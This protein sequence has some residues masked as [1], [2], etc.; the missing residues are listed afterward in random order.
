M[1]A[2]ADITFTR[3]GKTL[4]INFPYQK[5][6]ESFGFIGAL[7][8]TLKERFETQLEDSTLTF[9]SINLFFNGGFEIEELKSSILELVDAIDC[10][11]T[12]PTT[13]WKLP[14]CVDEE[15]TTDIL[16]YFKGDR[17]KADEYIKRFLSLEFRLIF[18]GFLPGF[19][20]LDGLPEEMAITRKATP[21]R[22]TIKGSLAVGGNQVGIYPQDSPGGW[23]VLGNCPIPMMDF[24]KNPPNPI[25]SLDR[26]QFF[27]I[28][29]E[30]HRELIDA[31]RMKTDHPYLKPPA[32]A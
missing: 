19:P 7:H 24:T 21:S 31:I 11:Q 13:L 18:Y 27:A 3:L 20:Y 22:V 15:F 10:S 17:T 30:E 32:D 16:E 29:T 25:H 12:K 14:V 9:N 26:I 1:F 4:I 23:N 6:D 28:S 2:K 8:N 5:N